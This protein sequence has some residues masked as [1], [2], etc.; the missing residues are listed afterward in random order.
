MKETVENEGI[1]HQQ[2]LVHKMRLLESRYNPEIC[3]LRS[4]FSSPGYHTTLQ[5]VEFIHSTRDSLSYALGLLDTE[6]IQ[7][8]ARA[9]DIIGQV[10]S[11]QETDRSRDT[12]GLW[13]WFYEEP[14][15]QMAPPDWNWADFCGSRLIQAISRHGHRFPKALREA[16]IQ[17]IEYA[18][19][20]IMKRDVGPDYT[21]IAILGAFV[22][23]IAGEQLGRGDYAEYGLKRLTKLYAYT[24]QRQVFQEYNS[25]VY[26]CIAIL[27]LSKLRAETMDS[28]VRELSDELI[29]MTWK[30][31]AEH[32][33]PGTE[34][35]SG[36]H[37]RCYETLLNNQSKAF[38]QVATKGKVMFF[39][40]EEL[41]YE[42]EWYKSGC[43]CPAAYL[44]LFTLPATKELKQLY[45]GDDSEGSGKWAT[46]FMTP[47]YS[48][49]AFT[50]SDLWNQR[51]PLLV[52]VKNEGWTEPAYIQLRCLHDGYDYCSARFK[53]KQQQ[54][55]VLFGIDFISNGGDT[56]PNLDLIDGCIEAA[57]LRLRL[58]I[59]GNLDGVIAKSIEGGAVIQLGDIEVRLRTWF[60]AF[61]AFAAFAENRAEEQ[62][63]SW[64]LHSS[65]D[66]LA[67]DMVLYAGPR[68]SIDFRKVEQAAF[69]FSLAIG[70]ADDDLVPLIE[71][72]SGAEL[73]VSDSSN[74]DQGETFSLSLRPKESGMKR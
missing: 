33:H 69:V 29:H 15:A 61:A 58:E 48:I 6:L 39:P 41:S 40:W 66:I 71:M 7:Y 35:W 36:P 60:A 68:R 10:V 24:Q 72:T 73:R 9:W 2:M 52:Y 11:L 17:A 25:P 37:A 22:T 28:R 47:Q 65:A 53:S 4:P 44:N 16:T 43:Y 49:G 42:E 5:Q 67:I 45:E 55:H 31:V 8:E 1:D 50:N 19:E 51:R 3:M 26:T 20:A 70:N 38:L 46:T 62:P 63:L 23:R 64:K 32:Y 56:H 13:S 27:E 74:S 34:Q 14:L 21:N 18:C 54:G 57:D 12:F 30:T 59:G